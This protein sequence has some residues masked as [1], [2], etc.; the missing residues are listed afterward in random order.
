MATICSISE[1]VSAGETL[2]GF[3]PNLYSPYSWGS[4]LE[5]AFSGMVATSRFF[6]TG[7][8]LFPQVRAF[9]PQ[10]KG[11]H[12]PLLATTLVAIFWLP[13]GY[14]PKARKRGISPDVATQADTRLTRKHRSEKREP[15]SGSDRERTF[16]QLSKIDPSARQRWAEGFLRPNKPF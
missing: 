11:I 5:G 6:G 2:C 4:A 12:S 8:H 3:T 10:T 7:Y 15:L 9:T 14:H 1:D 16:P 13:T